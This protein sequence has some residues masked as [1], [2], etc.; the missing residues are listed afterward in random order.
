[1]FALTSF[2]KLQTSIVV[3]IK[4]GCS[5]TV[6]FKHTSRRSFQRKQNDKDNVKQN[7]S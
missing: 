4:T 7:V 3:L 5:I 1:M 6:I 2:S